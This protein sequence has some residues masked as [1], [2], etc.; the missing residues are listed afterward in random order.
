MNELLRAWWPLTLS[1]F[2][3]SFEAV[4]VTFCIGRLPDSTV[5]IAAFSGIVYPVICLLE[6][7]IYSLLSTANALCENREAY[8][9]TLRYSLALCGFSAGLQLLFVVP[10]IYRL[11]MH[12]L[13]QTPQAV[14]DASFGAFLVLLPSAI[15][16]GIRRFYQG[17]LVRFGLA[18]LVG[19]GSM[20]RIGGMAVFLG[21]CLWFPYL[22]GAVA[23]AIACLVGV[24]LEAY[25]AFRTAR[26]VMDDYLADEE[27]AAC[28]VTLRA[29]VRFYMPL[30]FTSLLMC[31]A[32]PAVA[33]G[34]N[35][36]PMP[37]DSLVV[38]PV[39]WQLIVLLGAAGAA[40]PDLTVSFLARGFPLE[41]FN[42]FVKRL[43]IAVASL[44]AIVVFSPLCS[45][46]FGIVMKLPS[47]LWGLG[48]GT[49]I[50]VALVPLFRV[51]ISALVGRFL[52]ERDTLPIT[53]GMVVFLL[54]LGVLLPLGVVICWHWDLPGTAAG[55]LASTVATAAQAWWMAYRLR[56][57]F[58]W[59]TVF[60]S[61]ALRPGSLQ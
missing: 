44:T 51:G 48:R 45:A 21:L 19:K 39:A 7:P 13:L 2:C 35:R 24:S 23:G 3:L 15:L 11:C 10:P 5:Q 4:L 8:R 26:C 28:T 59:R 40:L 33:S 17:L 18:S 41:T 37:L 1:W 20:L 27:P 57:R 61:R 29:F 55:A 38:W 60:E 50:G 30:A 9:R 53:E 12:E 49:L 47:E 14:D 58:G 52:N 34:I 43:V 6:S 22:P 16:V 36:A 46:W 25:Y 54:T 31:I 56:H 42:L 32:Q